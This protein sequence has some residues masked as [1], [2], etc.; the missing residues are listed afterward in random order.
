MI[1]SGIILKRRPEDDKIDKTPGKQN[2]NAG[3]I[4]SRR[5]SHKD[6]K[7]NSVKQAR[8]TPIRSYT[9]TKGKE[10]GIPLKAYARAWIAN[11]VQWQK[12][13]VSKSNLS[14]SRLAFQ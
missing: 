10:E 4:L 8:K 13:H 2:K 7:L 3:I 9:L 5:R 6:M 11:L 1:L 14:A 12:A